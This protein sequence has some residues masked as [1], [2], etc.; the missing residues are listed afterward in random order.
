MLLGR[1]IRDEQGQPLQVEKRGRGER[2]QCL[3]EKAAKRVCPSHMYQATRRGVG[4]E[5]DPGSR[6][7]DYAV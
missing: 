4:H 5:E 6:S 3:T 1:D 2:E 7:I